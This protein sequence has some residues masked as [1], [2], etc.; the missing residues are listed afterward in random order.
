MYGRPRL[1]EQLRQWVSR[2]DIFELGHVLEPGIPHHPLHPPFLFSMAR[3]HGDYRHGSYSAANDIF[4]TGGHTGTHV[5]AIG[6]I[7][8][9]GRL[10][11]DV[12]ADSVQHKLQGL[13]RF[14]IDTTEPILCRGVLLDVPGALG[15]DVL[16]PAYEITPD[17]LEAACRHGGVQIEAGDAVLVRTGWARYWHEPRRFA[18]P[19]EGAPGVGLEAARWLVEQG[20]GLAGGDTIA[21][22]VVPSTMP[23]HM[24]L[25]VEKGIQIMEMLNL[26]ELARERCYTFLFVCLPLRIR[27]GTGS[28]IRPIAIR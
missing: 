7:S 20:M 9:D 4:C 17:D 12:G 8:C 23:V 27:G 2:G 1:A 14:G 6:H 19:D 25:L 26:E 21:Y 22:E 16:D 5:D 15:R 11:G 24:F 3:M 28:P 18:S 13:S 10:H